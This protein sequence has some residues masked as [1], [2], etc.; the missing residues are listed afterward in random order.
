MPCC[1]CWKKFRST[2]SSARIPMPDIRCIATDIIYTD[3]PPN[4]SPLPDANLPPRACVSLE[5][6]AAS[7][8]LISQRYPKP[9][10]VPNPPRPKRSFEYRNRPARQPRL[11]PKKPA[12][13]T[14]SPQEKPSSSLS[15]THRKRSIWRN[16]SLEPKLLPKR[17]AMLSPWQIILSPFCASPTSPLELCSRSDSRSCR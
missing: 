14:L 1:A 2:T 6:A 16:I 11:L 10:K 4:T 13:S 9:C 7:A 15:L 17:A 5:V 12:Y 8:Q 3:F